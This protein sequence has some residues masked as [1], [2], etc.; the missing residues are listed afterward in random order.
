MGNASEIYNRHKAEIREIASR[1]PASNIR[2]FGS[3][4]H[5]EDKD[6]SDIDLLV[7]T[8]PEATLFDLGGLQDE[9]QVLLGVKVDLLTPGDLPP[10]FRAAVI[11]EARAV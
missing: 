2:V 6:A 3:V 8:L 7:D 1:Y 4:L 11:S 9:L 5:G 10:R